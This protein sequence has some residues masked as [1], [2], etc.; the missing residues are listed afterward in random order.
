MRGVGSVGGEV[1]FAEE[2]GE[3]ER[4]VSFFSLV[5]SSSGQGR[6]KRIGMY[7]RTFARGA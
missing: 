4:P 2:P 1:D 3:G 6:A 5:L 7:E